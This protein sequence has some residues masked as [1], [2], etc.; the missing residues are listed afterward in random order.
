[1]VHDI[2]L[3]VVNQLIKESCFMEP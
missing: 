3:K 1:M 2:I